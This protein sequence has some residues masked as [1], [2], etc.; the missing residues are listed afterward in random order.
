MVTQNGVPI[1]QSGE[2]IAGIRKFRKL[3]ADGYCY[4][5]AIPTYVG[6]H[7]AMGWASQN[8]KLR[9][10]PVATIAARYARAGRFPTKY[11]TP[12]VCGGVCAPIHGRSGGKSDRALTTP[13]RRALIIAN[14]AR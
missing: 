1:F 2:L 6:G 3:F 14:W 10:T 4:V 12:E 5:A 9:Q 13:P 11:W 7:M 8:P